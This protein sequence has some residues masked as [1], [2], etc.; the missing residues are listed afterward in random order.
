MSL[1]TNSHKSVPYIYYIKVTL[2][3]GMLRFDLILL[4]KYLLYKVSLNGGL[5]RIFCLPVFVIPIPATFINITVCVLTCSGTVTLIVLPF[6]K[7]A[8]AILA[9]VTSGA[10]F[11]PLSINW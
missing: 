1:V 2:D 10:I 4:Y 5:L 11:S 8:Y 9:R 3:R 7:I 6:P